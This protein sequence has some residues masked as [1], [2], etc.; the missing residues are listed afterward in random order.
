MTASCSTSADDIAMLRESVRQFVARWKDHKALRER[1]HHLPGFDREAIKH[2]AAAG[3]LGILVPEDCGGLGLGFSAMR[4]VVEELGGALMAEP[5][6]ST[7]I[8]GGL[9]LAHGDNVALKSEL[10]AQVAAGELIPALAWQ[11]EG[12]ID[13]ADAAMRAETRNGC[14]ILSGRKRF[15]AGAAGADG[16]VVTA[17]FEGNVGLFWTPSNASGLDLSYEWRADGTPSGILTFRDVEVPHSA[18]VARTPYGLQR[19]LDET[20][21]MA[22]AEL[23]G[24]T[25]NLLTMT[26]DYMRTRVQ[27]G[28][29]IGAFQALQHRAVDLYI[30]QELSAAVVSDAV[31]LFDRGCSAA[32]RARIASRAKARCSD[33]GLRIGRD[34]VQLHGAIGFTDEYDVGLYLKRALVLSAWLGNADVHRRRSMR[35]AEA[36]RN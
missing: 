3:W 31:T 2:M 17:Q 7:V 19:A 16:F 32:E 20:L 1:R 18:I 15:V 13:I 24:V 10:L 26:L 25:R 36:D 34:A 28:K 11:E 4:A 9:A 14:V 29:P 27:F 21:V 33:A 30:Q 8:L 22:S 5:V 23:L 6:T 35:L 12:G